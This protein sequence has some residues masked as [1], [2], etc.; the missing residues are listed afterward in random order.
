MRAGPLAASNP[1]LSARRERNTVVSCRLPLD[2]TIFGGSRSGVDCAPVA[3]P[4]LYFVAYAGQLT[5]RDRVALTRPEFRLYEDGRGVTSSFW[6]DN[7]GPIAF[8]THQVV[9]VAA[10]D[11]EDARQVVGA[12]GRTPPA[13]TVDWA[14]GEESSS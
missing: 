8:E 3:P 10:D 1:Q 6:A 7:R 11:E 14:G 12:L 4:G 2:G 5:A 9:R 13:M